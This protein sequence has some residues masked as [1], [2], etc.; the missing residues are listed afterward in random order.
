MTFPSEKVSLNVP[1][2]ARGATGIV[3]SRM[4][5]CAGVRPPFR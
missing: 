4:F 3:P 2:N 1:A 5:A